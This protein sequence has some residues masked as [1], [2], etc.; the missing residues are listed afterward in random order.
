MIQ[1][2]CD[3]TL[4]TNFLWNKVAAAAEILRTNSVSVLEPDGRRVRE[5]KYL[6]GNSSTKA[7]LRPSASETVG[8]VY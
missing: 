4:L 1:S 2:S 6:A 3:E 8:G 5:L 7:F